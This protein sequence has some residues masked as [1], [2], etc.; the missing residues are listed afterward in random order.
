MCKKP[1]KNRHEQQLNKERQVHIGHQV[2]VGAR[3]DDLG[4]LVVDTAAKE[5]GNMLFNSYVNRTM[6][7]L[8]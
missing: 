4:E 8:P 3:L 6:P 2:R 1:N 5:K 7:V